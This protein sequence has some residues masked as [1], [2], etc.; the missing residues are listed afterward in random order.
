MA[1]EL[2][3]PVIVSTQAGRKNGKAKEPDLNNIEWS[4]AFSQDANVVIEMCRDDIDK[5]LHQAWLYLLKCRQ[6]QDT[7]TC[8]DMN[9]THMKFE[10]KADVQK[11]PSFETFT[12]EESELWT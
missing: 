4:N 1:R 12:K 8:V 3:I 10:E 6:G 2:G 11:A 5:E 7:E 9:F